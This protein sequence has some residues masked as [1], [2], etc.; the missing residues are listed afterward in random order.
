MAYQCMHVGSSMLF[1]REHDVRLFAGL[2]CKEFELVFGYLQEKARCM[3][4]WKGSKNAKNDTSQPRKYAQ[5]RTLTLEQEFSL[6]MIK[7]KLG[8]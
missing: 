3:H 2:S 7:L 1:T 8:L 5:Q 6:C 4:Y